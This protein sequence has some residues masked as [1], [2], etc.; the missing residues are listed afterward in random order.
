MKCYIG[1]S[2]DSVTAT[3]TENVKNAA[4]P[5][6]LGSYSGSGSMMGLFDEIRIMNR[7]ASAA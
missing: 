5:V 1:G 7:A 3:R 6:R 4:T 2:A